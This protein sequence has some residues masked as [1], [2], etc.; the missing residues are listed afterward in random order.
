MS[1][2]PMVQLP[3]F[4]LTIIVIDIQINKSLTMS[5]VVYLSVT[6]ILHDFRHERHNFILFHLD[7]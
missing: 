6:A 3:V 1:K 5:A 2:E 4:I 7:H